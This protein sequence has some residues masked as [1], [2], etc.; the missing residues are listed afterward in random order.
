MQSFQSAFFRCIINVALI[1]IESVWS[2]FF[3]I[4]VSPTQIKNTCFWQ[5]FNFS[6][7]DFL[8]V[9]FTFCHPCI[10]CLKLC[11]RRSL[12]YLTLLSSSNSA[13]T[14]LVSLTSHGVLFFFFGFLAF[15][16]LEH[17]NSW[18][19][20]IVQAFY[21]SMQDLSLIFIKIYIEKLIRNSKIH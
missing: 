9:T 6:T 5:G 20:N 13:Y 15:I 1:H 21:L 12:S 7:K 16:F 18:V 17:T 2:T 11:L 8:L 3:I 10:S 19:F 14:Y 4:I